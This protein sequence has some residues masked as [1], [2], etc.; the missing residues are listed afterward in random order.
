MYN[1]DFVYDTE[2][3]IIT[4]VANRGT[5]SSID[6]DLFDAWR[7]GAPGAA[8][9]AAPQSNNYWPNKVNGVPMNVSNIL[10]QLKTCPNI[11]QTAQY[12]AKKQVYLINNAM[13]KDLVELISG[14]QPPGAPKRMWLCCAT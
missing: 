12:G 7:R 11:G 2:N 4:H 6:G 5:L 3:E 10:T 9:A 8:A 13:N 14:S 1:P